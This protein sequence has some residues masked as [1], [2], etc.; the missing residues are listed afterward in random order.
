MPVVFLMYFYQ[1]VS[2][3]FAC[4]IR[5]QFSPVVTCRVVPKDWRWVGY[6]DKRLIQMCNPCAKCSITP[7]SLV[8]TVAASY[9][10]SRRRLLAGSMWYGV[11]NG[12]KHILGGYRPLLCGNRCGTRHAFCG[13]AT[14]CPCCATR[15]CV[16]C[17]CLHV[18]SLPS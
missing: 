11:P 16:L 2:S 5:S 17:N 15:T 8:C 14:G 12:S 13:D 1:V 18:D 9:C 4:C 3:L 7:V 10:R 6:V